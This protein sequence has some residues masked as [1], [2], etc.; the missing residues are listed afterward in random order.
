[1]LAKLKVRVGAVAPVGSLGQSRK[2]VAASLKEVAAINS[3]ESVLEIKLD[4][5]FVAFV[6]MP[7][8]PRPATVDRSII[9][10]WAGDSNL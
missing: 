5:A 9:T 1:M 8:G 2:D 7:F 4:K 3:I 10:E 6:G